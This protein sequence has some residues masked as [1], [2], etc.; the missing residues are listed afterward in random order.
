MAASVTCGIDVSQAELVI[1]EWPVG[2]TWTAPNTASGIATVVHALQRVQPTALVCEAT[3]GLERALVQACLT[4][5]LPL[6]VVNP[7]HVAHFRRALGQSAKTDA[8]DA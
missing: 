6:A 2:T 3:G 1:A 8:L 4:A 5:G 7:A